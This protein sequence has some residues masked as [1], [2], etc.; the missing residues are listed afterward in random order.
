MSGHGPLI[1]V[2]QLLADYI[3]G[4]AGSW[5]GRI[6]MQSNGWGPVLQGVGNWGA[7]GPSVENSMDAIW[8]RRVRRGEQAIQPDNYDWTTLFRE[9]QANGSDYVEVYTPSF[10]MSARPLLISAIAAFDP[11]CH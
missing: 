4:Q 9:A 5:S 7:T 8:T 10:S 2:S 1:D 3:V 11:P 6:T